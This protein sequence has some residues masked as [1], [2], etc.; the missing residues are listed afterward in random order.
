MRS[1]ALAFTSVD[2]AG[3]GLEGH[4]NCERDNVYYALGRMDLFL[5][6]STVDKIEALSERAKST[7]NAHADEMF[8][9]MASRNTN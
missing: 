8:D 7:I 2:L 4:H 9:E 6:K 3:V 1:V 5:F